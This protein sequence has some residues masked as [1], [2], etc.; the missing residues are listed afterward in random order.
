MKTY[1]RLKQH[2]IRLQNTKQL[3]AQQK[4]RIGTINNIKLLGGLA[5]NL[6]LI[7]RSGSQHLVTC[8]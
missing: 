8:S 7:F 5:P 3:E 1:I 6:T 4:Y 2:K